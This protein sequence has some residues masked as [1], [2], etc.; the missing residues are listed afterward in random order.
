MG[1]SKTCP[2]CKQTFLSLVTYMSHIKNN[3]NKVSP[4]M[5]TKDTVELKWSWTKND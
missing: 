5:L 4:D 2:L 1:F 3:H